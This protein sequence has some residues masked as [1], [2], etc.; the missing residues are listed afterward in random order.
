MRFYHSFNLHL[1]SIYLVAICASSYKVLLKSLAHFVFI[2]FSFTDLQEFLD[3]LDTSL[4]PAKCISDFFF[5]CGLPIPFL[6][7][8]STYF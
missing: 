2:G 3:I 1:L 8:E 4:G 6:V 5:L 7:V